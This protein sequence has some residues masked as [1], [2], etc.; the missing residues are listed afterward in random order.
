MK[1]FRRYLLF[2]I[3]VFLGGLLIY[4]FLWGRLF[5][6]SPMILGFDHWKSARAVVYFH[7]NETTTEL[8]DIDKIISTVENYHRLKFKKTLRVFLTGSDREYKR[9][10]GTT[11]RFVSMPLHGR[12]FIS[13]RA[14]NDYRS[15]RID[16]DI[17][18]KH[19]LSHSLLYQNMGLWRSLSYP[20]W[21]MEG[22]GMISAGQCGTGGY[23]TFSQVAETMKKGIFAEP[24]DW[25]TIISS[26]G[27]TVKKMQLDN[28]FHFIYSEYAF[29]IEELM[30]QYGNEKMLGFLKSSMTESDFTG[31]FART[32]GVRLDDFLDMFKNKY[33]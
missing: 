20:G 19:E 12:I 29:I 31:L 22:L 26:E 18:L 14:K 10:T 8:E 23:Y 24:S 5:P 21:F 11:A 9:L 3:I 1:M 27:E 33:H 4:E 6:I 15:G 7:K 16:L 17:Y 2:T 28:K 13:S 30:N 25:G 32:F